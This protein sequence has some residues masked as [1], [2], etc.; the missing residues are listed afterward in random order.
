MNTRRYPE[1]LRRSA[2]IAA[3]VLLMG[4]AIAAAHF[5]RVA[6]HQEF[7]SGATTAIADSA[8]AICAAQLHS[9]AA[10]AIVPAF[11][12]PKPLH[13]SVVLAVATEPLCAYVGHCFG[14]A[15]PVSV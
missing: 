15:P 3:I 1:I 13:Q 12:A 4:Q 6:G 11:D 10:H 8:C 7:S 9:P 5:H 2:I 14:R